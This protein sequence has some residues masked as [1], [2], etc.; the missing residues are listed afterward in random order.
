MHLFEFDRES[1]HHTSTR[2]ALRGLDLSL[3]AHVGCG[4]LSRRLPV[5]LSGSEP[6][7]AS[8][9]RRRERG[10]PLRHDSVDFRKLTAR[11]DGFAPASSTATDVP[12]A[13]ATTTDPRPSATAH[14]CV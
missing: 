7:H 5:Q 1:E 12:V 9:R 6:D 2:S 10:L 14:R 8:M 3:G 13:S 4:L 11:V